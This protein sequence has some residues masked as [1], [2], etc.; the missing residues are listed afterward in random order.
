MENP[1]AAIADPKQFALIQRKLILDNRIRSGVGWFYWIAGLSLVNTIAFLVGIQMHFVVGL[2]ITQ[3]IDGFLYA[4]TQELNTM[5]RGILQA[6]GVFLD[7]AIAGFF[8]LLGFFGRKR[9]AWVVILGMV[10][11]LFDAVLM[12]VFQDW[13]AAAFHALALYGLWT[14]WRAIR[15]LAALDKTSATQPVEVLREQ[16]AV[17][18]PQSAPVNRNRFRT[19]AILVGLIFLVIVA[20]MVIT[21]FQR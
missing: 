14:G 11:Y 3:I 17:F 16:F 9:Y 15:Q 4:F 8:A 13:L 2:A 1:A 20:G 7:V 18:Q 5:A 19:S 12:I 6:L 21:S 10:I